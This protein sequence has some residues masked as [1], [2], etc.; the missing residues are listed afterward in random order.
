[1]GGRDISP[2]F[3]VPMLLTIVISEADLGRAVAKFDGATDE[4]L[5]VE[6]RGGRGGKVEELEL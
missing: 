1:M 3:A 2:I 6:L 5:Q 4:W